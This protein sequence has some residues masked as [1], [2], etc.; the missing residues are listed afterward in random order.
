[1]DETRSRREFLAGVAGAGVGWAL[2]GRGRSAAAGRGA[3]SAAAYRPPE[4]FAAPPIDVVRIGFVG[5]GLQGG[6]HVRNFLRIPGVEVVAVCDIDGPRA[7]EV[8]HW[9]VEAGQRA[10]DL[11]TRGEEDYRRMC[12]RTDIDLVFNSTP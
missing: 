6:S 4:G 12:E 8:G 9:V 5:V 1:M 3:K 11:Y 10:P 7:A 2:A